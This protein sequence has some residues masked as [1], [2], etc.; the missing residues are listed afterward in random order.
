MYIK[1]FFGVAVFFSLLSLSIYLLCRWWTLSRTTT[2][3][4][5]SFSFW[6]VAKCIV[7]WFC[8]ESKRKKKQQFKFFGRFCFR[9]KYKLSETWFYFHFAARWSFFL[10]P[11]PDWY[12]SNI[13][14]Q[15]NKHFCWLLSNLLRLLNWY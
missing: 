12:E 3:I 14:C 9:L 13:F 1:I 5:F 2:T 7:T 6:N 10:L 11:R 15:L 4:F 8:F